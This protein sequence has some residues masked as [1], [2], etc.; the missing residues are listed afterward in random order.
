[1]T[2]INRW[3]ESYLS[4][5]RTYNLKRSLCTNKFVSDGKTWQRKKVTHKEVQTKETINALRLQWKRNKQKK[6]LIHRSLQNVQVYLN[7]QPLIWYFQTKDSLKNTNM[8]Y[9]DKKSMKKIQWASKKQVNSL[10]TTTRKPAEWRH[11]HTE[12]QQGRNWKLL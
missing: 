4:S 5:R 6:L 9:Y 8:L 2:M 3:S 1:M 7:G 12:Q 11:T 10:T